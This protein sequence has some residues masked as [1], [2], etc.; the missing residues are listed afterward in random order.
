MHAGCAL[1]I[2]AERSTIVKQ[3]KRL[4]S[5]EVAYGRMSQ[6][7]NPFGDGTASAQT[8]AVLAR[9]FKTQSAMLA[10]AA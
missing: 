10:E 5:D 9:H 6:A 4:S 3:A 7:G 2:G 8:V 1:L